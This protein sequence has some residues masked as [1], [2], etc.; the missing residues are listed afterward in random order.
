MSR[1]TAARRAR[2]LYP[3]VKDDAGR[4]RIVGRRVGFEPP[5]GREIRVV[6]HDGVRFEVLVSP[7]QIINPKKLYKRLVEGDAPGIANSATLI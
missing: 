4:T 3:A 7:G 2:A 1:M 6:E 5:A